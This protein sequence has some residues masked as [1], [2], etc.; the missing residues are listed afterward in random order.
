MRRET[1]IRVVIADDDPI[2]RE[3]LRSVVLRRNPRIDLVGE[4]ADGAEAINLIAELKPDV[5]LLDLLMPHLPGIDTLRELASGTVS[6]RTI[7]LCASIGKR[8]IVEA[9]QYGARGV[10]LKKSLR[11]LLE[12]IEAVVD[13]HYW[14]EDRK[15]RDSAEIIRD[16]VSA[17]GVEP[18]AAQRYKLTN[19]ELQIMSLV[20]LGNTNREIGEALD[21]S[22]ETVKRHLANIFDKVGMSN[23]LE[24]A[25]FAVDRQLVSL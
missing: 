8:Q 25:M 10:L 5:L 20:T 15:V 18:K 14:I 3:L 4:A 17:S 19:R 7:V 24:L 6:V 23:R 21:I 2:V 13:G 1:S 11:S 16:L 9:L 22:D 12:C